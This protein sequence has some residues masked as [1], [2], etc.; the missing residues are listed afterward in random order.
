[1]GI[2][3]HEQEVRRLRRSADWALQKPFDPHDTVA[4]LRRLLRMVPPDSEDA[5]FAHRHLAELTVES[6][7]WSAALSARRLVRGNPDDDQGWALLAL[8]LTLMSHYRAAVRAYRRALALSPHNPWYAHNLGHL[9]D[10]GLDRPDDGLPLLSAAH[11]KE[12]HE[13]EI[14]SSYAHAL[15]RVGKIE[16]ARDLL[17]RSIRDGGNRDQRALLA[18]LD[19][20]TAE[21]RTVVKKRK[22]RAPAKGRQKSRG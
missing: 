18:W 20:A 12:P 9:L 19:E 10:V 21:R 5:L 1:M 15:G 16:E 7:P 4:I 11:R 2:D 8:A 22:G 3:A 13:T 14:A 17:R 6:N